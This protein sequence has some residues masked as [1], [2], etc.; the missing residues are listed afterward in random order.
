MNWLNNMM[1]SGIA[2]G[3]GS[4]GLAQQASNN[5]TSA[6]Q[7]AYGGYMSQGAYNSGPWT[8]P[9]WMFNGIHMDFQDFVNKVFPED[10]AEK[11]AF[12][13]KYSEK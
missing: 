10:T 9:K 8:A 5:Y 11:T 2:S 1:G 6:Q 3:L 7:Q 13:L 4:M 12:I